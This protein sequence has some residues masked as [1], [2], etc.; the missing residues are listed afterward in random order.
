MSEF[1]C[2]AWA[3]EHSSSCCLCNC[4][5]GWKGRTGVVFSTVS[6]DVKCHDLRESG[7]IEQDAD[8]VAFIHRDDV[9]MSREDWEKRNP[10]QS[11]PEDLPR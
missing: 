8:V 1:S 11:Y 2:L 4:P 7:S 5:G 3:Y 9:H 6:I 10:G